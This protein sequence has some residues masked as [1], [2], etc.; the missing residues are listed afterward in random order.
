MAEKDEKKHQPSTQKL[1]RLKRE[2]K[3]ADSPDLLS[4]ATLF[5]LTVSMIFL[6]DKIGGILLRGFWQGFSTSS[7]LDIEQNKDLWF[8]QILWLLQV[9]ALPVVIALLVGGLLKGINFRLENISFNW[10]R[11]NPGRNA[12]Q[13]FGSKGLLQFLIALA[14]VSVILGIGFIL[15]I[16]LYQDFFSLLQSDLLFQVQDN[17]QETKILLAILALCFLIFG[18]LDFIVKKHAFL[19]EHMMTDREI[20]DE[21]KD[22]EGS[23][24]VKQKRRQRAFEI[25]SSRMLQDAATAD[26]LIVNPIHVAVALKW[27]REKGSA[28]VCVAKGQ[29]QIALRIKEIAIE[30]SVPV[31]EDIPTARA[32]NALCEIGEEV[33]PDLYAAVAM[34]IR[35]ADSIRERARKTPFTEVS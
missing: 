29:D 18:S 16:F 10:Q 15:S 3:T 30:N 31:H 24:E 13:K 22:N 23:P 34:A 19:K 4:A 7:H 11:L 9:F 17:L 26:V 12:A 32:L 8:E 33:P 14:K 5:S 27:S 6:A 20:K 35:F 28:P 1:D 21:H 25:S 2:G